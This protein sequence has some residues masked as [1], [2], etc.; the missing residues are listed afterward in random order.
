M[1]KV[2]KH[3][4]N[5]ITTT[6]WKE[7][8]VYPHH[9]IVLG[10]F[11][12][13]SK[14]SLGIG[15][16]TDLFPLIDWSNEVGLDTIQLLPLNET[17]NDNSPYNALS[18]CALDPM[19]I[20]ISKLL[21]NETTKLLHEDLKSLK[22]LN[23]FSRIK[24]EKLKKR[25]YDFLFHYYRNVFEKVKK[26]AP[27]L[28][29][30]KQNSSWLEEYALF[31]VLKDL[32]DGKRWNQWTEKYRNLSEKA[33]YPLLEKHKDRIEFYYFLQY[34]CFSQMTAVKDYA[35]KK[36]ILIKGDIPILINADSVDLWRDRNVF[37]LSHVAGCPPDDNDANGQKWGFPLFNWE[38]MKKN[39]YKWWRRRLSVAS[40]CYHMYRV[41]HAVGFFRIWSILPDEDAIQGRF[42]PRNPLK[43][44]KQGRE[45]L[46]MMIKATPMLPIAEDLGVIPKIV[47][48]VLKALGICGIKIFRQEKNI[49]RIFIPLNK[50][51]PLSVTTLATH[52]QPVMSEWW[53]EE[54]KQAKKLAKF[55][56]FKYSYPMTFEERLS[57]L[58]ASHRTSSLFHIN[59]FQEYLALIPSF[60]SKNPKEERINVAGSCLSQN[61][62]YRF[63]PTIEEIA[64]NKKLTYAM[65][66]ITKK[67]K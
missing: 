64:S 40:S 62:T 1:E 35:T 30:I 56:N 67:I 10:L 53:L 33:F 21:E 47:P 3:L 18:S 32:H 9:G 38:K 50:Y 66:K 23:N 46:T 60:V 4:S 57:L 2:K 16:F 54:K 36:K 22:E 51:K 42:L 31:R 13:R 8:G 65:K 27:Y 7:I 55:L 15:E 19:Y 44:A 29:F 24:Y 6:H 58:I 52:D 45:L 43:W 28:T 61:W 14:D 37:D 17:S 25:K 49:F 48:R 26:T 59:L 12:L 63:L 11:S 34:L 41:D 20:G 5:C 39:G